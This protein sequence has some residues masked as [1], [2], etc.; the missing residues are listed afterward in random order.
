MIREILS[1][2]ILSYQYAKS[3][4]LTFCSSSSSSSS[5]QAVVPHDIP[6][7]H[8]V[9]CPGDPSK[10]RRYQDNY[11]LTYKPTKHLPAVQ[12]LSVIGDA[13]VLL[14]LKSL[15]YHYFAT[16]FR[17]YDW[18]HHGAGATAVAGSIRCSQVAHVLQDVLCV[19]LVCTACTRRTVYIIILIVSTAKY[20]SSYL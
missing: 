19:P 17:D 10:L 3:S 7:L 4:K 16:I 9:D 13:S 15:Y 11:P 6:K 12:L 5:R 1:Q 2:F 14:S 18:S 20:L 8:S